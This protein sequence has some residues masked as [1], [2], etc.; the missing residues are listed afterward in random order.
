MYKSKKNISICI[1]I[2]L[3]AVLILLY[4]RFTESSLNIAETSSYNSNVTLYDDVNEDDWFFNDVKYVSENNLM[5]GTASGIFSPYEE[6]T[7]GMIVTILWRLE[8]KPAISINS[9]IDVKSGTYYYDAVAWAF[10]NEIVNGYNDSYFGPEDIITREQL[11]TILYRYVESKNSIVLSESNLSGFTDFKQ[12]NDYAMDALKWAN[13]NGIITGI[14]LDKI[15]PQ[16]S[17]IRCQ[18]AAVLKRMCENIH[19]S[20]VNNILKESAEPDSEETIE[21]ENA[22]TSTDGEQSDF[23]NQSS[24]K[25]DHIINSNDLGGFENTDNEQPIVK[26]NTAYAAPGENVKVDIEIQ[27]N[28]G[29][30]GMILSLEYDN[31]VMKLL[32]VKNGE[33]VSDVLNLTTSKDMNTGVRFVWDGLELVPAEIRNGTLLVLEFEIFDTID[34]GREYPLNISYN[35]GDIV[36]NNLEEVNLKIEQGHLEV[37]DVKK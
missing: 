2:L 4:I 13:V 1:F 33:A 36:N 8:G 21:K 23:S 14:A 10:E 20:N 37:K 26:V 18:V 17:A 32:N 19:I 25:E 27:N 6:T 24:D 7:R 28:P 22:F 34:V 3:A 9:F 29:I 35:P 30:L 16:G 5:N 12:I 31:T 15:A 11:A